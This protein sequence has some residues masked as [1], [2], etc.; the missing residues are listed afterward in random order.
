MDSSTFIPA[1]DEQIIK[2][3]VQNL[4][5]NLLFSGDDLSGWWTVM[6]VIISLTTC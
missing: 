2:Y 4:D 1:K 3:P 6:H 5:E